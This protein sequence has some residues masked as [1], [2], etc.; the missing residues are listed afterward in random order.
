MLL[1]CI[2]GPTNL[3]LNTIDFMFEQ[4]VMPESIPSFPKRITFCDC[5]KHDNSMIDET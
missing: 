4:D 5:K 2:S 3:Q 1:S